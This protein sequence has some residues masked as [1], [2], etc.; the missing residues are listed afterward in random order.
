MS[1]TPNDT[2]R[3]KNGK[4]TLKIGS[5]TKHLSVMFALMCMCSYWLSE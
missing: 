3:D 4:G 2:K 1:N 5:V